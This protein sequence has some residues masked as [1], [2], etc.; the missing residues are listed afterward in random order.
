MNAKKILTRLLVAALLLT[1]ICGCS[2]KNKDQ[3]TSEQTTD[4]PVDTSPVEIEDAGIDFWIENNAGFESAIVGTVEDF[5][6][7]AVNGTVT[8][9]SYKGTKEH[10]IIPAE[11]NGLPVTAIAD[12]AFAGPEKGTATEENPEE[13]PTSFLKTLIIPES[14]TTIG[15]G[16]LARCDTLHSLQT[17][18]MGAN[19]ESPQYL[20]YLFGATTHEDNARDIPASLK[21]LRITG[22]WR[23]M[24]AY[25][26]FDCNDLICISL[27][28]DVT[29]LEKFALFNGESL[30]QIDGLENVT[31]F[32]D[33][34]LM[35]CSSLQT[36][37]ISNNAQSIGFGAFEGCDSLCAM[38]LPFAGYS[39]TEN[40]YLAY[41]FGA[42]EPDFSQGFYP[43]K[44]AKITL[45]TACK[46]LGDYAFFECE[47]LKEISLPEGL[48]TIGVRA[49]YGCESLWSI[50]I[51]NSVMQIRELAFANC[52][53]LTEI[54]FGTGLTTLG[55][56]AFYNCDSLV[57]VSL[58][59]SLKK[60]PASCF[61]G[62]I[63]L[64][65]INLGGATEVGDQAFRHC[66]A[67]KSVTSASAV[68]FGEGNE[69]A[70]SILQGK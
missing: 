60:I 29:V 67:L 42:A 3:N 31:V 28:E 34:A 12:G 47:T 53:A 69:H 65:S 43:K 58:P 4:A 44:L 41:I 52:D 49:F 37:T 63:S 1:S 16:I 64:E 54:T 68:T 22:E 40:T 39:H 19:K 35:N 38:T 66:N 11:M 7:E 25:S 57:K 48:A 14:I 30:R 17:P 45:T 55:I 23:S 46:K 10:L 2:N 56:N 5:E 62:C 59:A 13:E 18:L 36:V 51:P 33:R 8:V 20:G 61:A 15:T 9:L 26:L 6:I 27:P 32:G 50:Q 21:C 24:P 70:K